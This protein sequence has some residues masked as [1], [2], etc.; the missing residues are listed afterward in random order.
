MIA[1]STPLCR[2]QV[3]DVLA[4]RYDLPDQP[5]AGDDGRG[6]LPHPR[7]Q[8]HPAR[9][10]LPHRLRRRPPRPPARGARRRRTSRRNWLPSARPAST[11]PASGSARPASPPGPGPASRRPPPAPPLPPRH[12]RRRRP[13]RRRRR[14]RLLAPYTRNKEAERDARRDL[15]AG[16]S[17]AR[18]LL[19]RPRRARH[20]LLFPARLAR[21]ARRLVGASPRRP[22]DASPR[23][24]PPSRPCTS[25]APPTPAARSRSSC[26]VRRPPRPRRRRHRRRRASSPATSRLQR[27]ARGRPDRGCSSPRRRPPR[28]L[29]RT[30]TSTL[31]ADGFAAARTLGVEIARAATAAARDPRRPHR[32]GARDRRRPGRARPVTA[33]ARLATGRAGPEPR[34]CSPPRSGR[35][36]TART[37]P[38]SCWCRCSGAA[39][40]Y[41]AA[42]SPALARASTTPSSATAT[43]WTSPATTCSGTSPRTTRCSSTPPPISPAHLLPDARFTRSGRTGAEQSAVGRDARARLARP[44]RALGDGRVQL[45]PL[46]P[47]RPQGPDRALRPRARRRHPRPRRPRHRAPARDRRQLRPPRHA[48]R[49]AG[50]LLRALAA[51]RPLARALR[52]RPPALGPRLLRRRASTPC[53]SSRSAC[54]TTASP[55]PSLAARADLG[56]RRRAGMVLPPGRGR[57]RRPLPLQDPRLRDGHRRPLPLGRVGLPGDGAPRPHRRRSPQAQIWINHPGETIQCGFGRPSYWGGCGTLPR[58][59]QYRGLAVVAFDGAAAAARLHPR[60]VSPRR[61][62]RDR[63]RTPTAA[64]ARCGDGLAALLADGPLD[65]VATGPSAGCE[66]RL[67]GRHGRWIVRLGETGRHGDLAAFRA[68]L[69]RPRAHERPPTAASSLTIPTTA[70]SSSARTAGRGRRPHARPGTTGPSP[71][72]P[73]TELPASRTDTDG[74]DEHRMLRTDHCRAA[75]S[76]ALGLRHRRAAGDVRVMWYSD[77]VEGEVIEDLLNRFMAD[78]PGINVILDNVAYQ[79]DP[80]AAADPARGRPGPRHRPRHQPQGAGRALAR[81]HAPTS[82]TPTTGATNFG[83]TLDWMRPDGSK[84]HPRL[85]DPAHAHRR[86]RQ[87]DAVRAGRRRRCPATRP[88]GTTGSRPRPRS[89]RARAARRLRH[90]PLRPPH[91]RPGISYGA[92][93]IGADG[94]PAP[95]DEG[96]RRPSSS[97]LVGWT[98]DGKMLKEIWVSA[99]G[100]TYRAARRR[101]HQRPARLLLFRQLA[102]RRTSRPR[103][104]TPSTGWR[105]ARPAAPPP[106]P[107][108]QGGAG[109]VAI[110]YTKNPEEVA[111][112]M[113]YLASEPVVK[114]FTERTLFLPAHKGV[115]AKGGLNFETDDPNVQAGARDVRRRLAASRARRRRCCRRGNGPTPTTPR[116]SPAPAR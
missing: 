6:L 69:R 21:T 101:L 42:L 28:R 91:L 38:T 1:P 70:W 46:L 15:P 17:H 94:M 75:P 27:S 88:P 4:T 68:P 49:R 76:A 47:D 36:P 61:L 99:A 54:A 44:F 48:H 50:P 67:A 55:C 106:A 95:V 16:A 23:S 105:P 43:G 86:L 115:I 80:G 63:A 22:A 62:R 26:R 113:D 57:L 72:T 45:R 51:R 73:D 92:N 112:V 85:H 12:L 37:A 39:R 11:S 31:E 111:K 109:L 83:D 114:E 24:R 58:V 108:C 90:R 103:S 52:H 89:P 8:L 110:K 107:A 33:L 93:Y 96:V 30:S 25:S 66:L 13:L 77:G 7:P 3:S 35:S 2:W 65:R 104:A 14:G 32:R 20:P 60:L 78:N 53:R 74:E 116:S 41:A 10:S 100:S 18:G 87:H 82:R 64:F 59:H 19:R 81:P 56:R 40:R 9:I 5:M 97:K 34:R 29:P 71:G 98:E 84:R 102:G 79:V